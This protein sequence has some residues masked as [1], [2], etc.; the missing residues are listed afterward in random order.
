MLLA[1]LFGYLSAHEA[2]SG[3][4]VIRLVVSDLRPGVGM[5]QHATILKVVKD[6]FIL[7]GC[8]KFA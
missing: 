4:A 1:I 2:L 6:G 3:Y 7:E 5:A 8:I